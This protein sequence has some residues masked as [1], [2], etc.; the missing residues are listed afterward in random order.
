M[1]RLFSNLRKS[2]LKSPD[3]KSPDSHVISN[4][5]M[6]GYVKEKVDDYERLVQSQKYIDFNDMPPKDELD[7]M[8]EEFLADFLGDAPGNERNM[9]E[10]MMRAQSDQSK[11]KIIK[12][13]STMK[14]NII[15]VFY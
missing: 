6:E 1:Q 10:K 12:M 8:F 9:R 14:V 3:T 15:F 13:N 11:W 7:R 5:P 4:P 2:T